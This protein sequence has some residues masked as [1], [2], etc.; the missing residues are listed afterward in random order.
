MKAHADGGSSPLVP[1]KG[2]VPREGV[3]RVRVR[4]C[5]C[6]PMNVAHHAA[7]VPWL[8]MGRIELLRDAGV[9]YAAMERAGVYLV[10]ASLGVRYRRPIVYD[11]VVEIRTRVSG[12]GKVRI[13]HAYD[14]AVV[15]RDGRA[16][17]VSAASAESVIACVGAAGRPRALPAW[18]AGD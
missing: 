6:D 4:Y 10:V 17:E 5:E 13:E 14:L 3:I 12:G 7:Y 2:R 9:S 11:D 18:L 15:E 16:C 8:E 1:P